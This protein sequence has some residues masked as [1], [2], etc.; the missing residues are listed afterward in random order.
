MQSAAGEAIREEEDTL[1]TSSSSCSSVLDALDPASDGTPGNEQ[2]LLE[3]LLL[4]FDGE[5]TEPGAARSSLLRQLW[6]DDAECRDQAL[7]VGEEA[8]STQ[9]LA[10]WLI[11]A[12]SAKDPLRPDRDRCLL[13]EDKEDME[14][15][16]R[17][18]E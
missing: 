11:T 9:L 16:D 13:E 1:A 6:L 2:P 17:G 5:G 3:P 12:I 14:K 8:L 15:T 10:A 18:E 4:A 7:G